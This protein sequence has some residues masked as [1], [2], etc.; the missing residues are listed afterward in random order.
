MQR[1]GTKGSEPERALVA[2]YQDLLWGQKA[3][4]YTREGRPH[5]WKLAR[6]QSVKMVNCSLTGC[7]WGFL[8]FQGHQ[9]GARYSAPSRSLPR[10]QEEGKLN[11]S[12]GVVWLTQWFDSWKSETVTGRPGVRVDV[13]Q[14]A[15]G[16]EEAPGGLL[17]LEFKKIKK[18]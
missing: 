18:W 16:Q 11:D 1:M 12:A 8:H 17:K 4:N 3:R 14:T 9:R 13:P 5:S 10:I 6:G 15:S 2:W 7:G